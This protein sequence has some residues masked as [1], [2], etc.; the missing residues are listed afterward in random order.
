M[1]RD[2]RPE[3]LDAVFDLWLRGNLDAHAFLPAAYWEGHADVVRE[4]LPQ[5]ELL[6]YDAGGGPLGFLGLD[7]AYVAGLFVGREVR[8]QGIGRALLGAAKQ[9]R[10]V[11]E[12]HVYQE[13]RRACAFYCR[14]GFAVCGLQRDEQT[15][16]PEL[17]LRWTRS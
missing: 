11:L 5:A 7:G 2:F 1:I 9:R 15:G 17:L 14:E 10:E 12:L 6:V 16:A 4:M 8:S 3:D 13:N